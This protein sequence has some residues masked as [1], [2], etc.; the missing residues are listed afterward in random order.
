V[1]RD[2]KESHLLEI[3]SC[4]EQWKLKHAELS[5]SMSAKTSEIDELKGQIARLKLQLQQM[6]RPQSDDYD[7]HCESTS[8]IG[9]ISPS[10]T[11]E[12]FMMD[13]DLN[14][15][16]LADGTDDASRILWTAKYHEEA[17]HSL[18]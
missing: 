9:G 14:K 5:R 6:T 11:W 15:S 12:H 16:A 13:W 10:Q 3:K 8:S 2:R 17:E 1:Y 4:L 7:D 18:C